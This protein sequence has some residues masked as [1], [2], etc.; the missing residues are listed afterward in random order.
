M[1]KIV[2]S[3]Q[4]LTVLWVWMDADKLAVN[5]ILSIFT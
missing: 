2:S 1:M 3:V 5:K 4:M